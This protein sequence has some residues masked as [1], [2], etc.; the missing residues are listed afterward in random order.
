MTLLDLIKCD[1]ERLYGPCGLVARVKHYLF[2]GGH[3][4]RWV[5]WFRVTCYAKVVSVRLAGHVASGVQV[6]RTRL[7]GYALW[8][9]TS[10]CTWGLRVSL[11]R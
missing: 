9:R 1:F 3:P 4:I 10:D 8:S 2:N 11:C 6:W 5:V 7:D